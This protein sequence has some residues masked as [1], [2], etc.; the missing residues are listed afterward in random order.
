MDLNLLEIGLQEM[1]AT[2]VI[3]MFSLVRDN[4]IYMTD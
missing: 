1:L 4:V 3:C 2:F